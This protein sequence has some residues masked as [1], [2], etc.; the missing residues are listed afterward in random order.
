MLYPINRLR[1]DEPQILYDGSPDR[2]EQ[3]PDSRVA[4]FVRGEAGERMTEMR[5]QNGGEL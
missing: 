5:Q 2:I 1:Q 3:S 4:Q